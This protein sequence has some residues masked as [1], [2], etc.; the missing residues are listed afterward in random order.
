MR[1]SEA[2]HDHGHQNNSHT[3]PSLLQHQLL[4]YT[5]RIEQTVYNRQ[6]QTNM[7][8]KDRS[9]QE[10]TLNQTDLNLIFNIFPKIFRII[11]PEHKNLF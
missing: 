6:I 8:N 10:I 4:S 2:L 7:F 11:L 5:P 9:N 1:Q 3:S